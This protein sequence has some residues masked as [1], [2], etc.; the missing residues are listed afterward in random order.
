MEY[1]LYEAIFQCDKSNL[2]PRDV[3]KQPELSIYIDDFG[4][5]D[6]HCLVAECDGQVVGAVWT[7]VLS[8]QIKGYG[9]VDDSTPEFAI[10]L[11]ENYRNRGIGT[12]LMKSMLQLL[13]K[14]G[15][16]KTSLA[17]QKDNFAVKMYNKVGFEIIKELKKEYLMICKLNGWSS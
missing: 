4:K 12:A 1:F 5:K 13:K 9:Y 3:I 8:D 10:S 14:G 15:Y 16:K 7:R 6:D 11:Y 17:V 2:L